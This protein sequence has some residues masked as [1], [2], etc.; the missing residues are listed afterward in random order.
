MLPGR[1]S[2]AVPAEHSEHGVLLTPPEGGAPAAAEPPRRVCGCLLPAFATTLVTCLL[3]LTL[4]ALLTVLFTAGAESPGGL[5]ATIVLGLLVLCGCIGLCGCIKDSCCNDGFEEKGPVN[6]QEQV[7]RI[8]ALTEADVEKEVAFAPSF[9]GAQG[10]STALSTAPHL[11]HQPPGGSKEHAYYDLLGVE[12]TATAAQIK[13]AYYKL[14]LQTHPDK[15]PGDAT[16]LQRFQAIGQAYQVLSNEQLRARY[17]A[18]GV[19]GVEVADFMDSTAL[20]VMLFGSEKFVDLVG[21]LPVAADMDAAVQSAAGQL[22][23]QKRRRAQHSTSHHITSHH[24]PHHTTPHHTTPHHTT[25]VMSPGAA[26]RG[27]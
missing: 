13:K 16:A 27:V 11:P 10:Q 14:A 6:V 8:M 15:H 19:E 25:P 20:F 21:E 17:D 3:C 22:L 12:T 1:E 5:I 23:R 7:D 9:L 26:Q 2:M 18:E 24:T 4:P